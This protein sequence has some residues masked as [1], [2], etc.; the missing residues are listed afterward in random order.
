[1][2]ESPKLLAT[3]S[4]R[5]NCPDPYLAIQ[6][7]RDVYSFLVSE[8]KVTNYNLLQENFTANWLVHHALRNSTVL[9]YIAVLLAM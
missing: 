5:Y 9:F 6:Y 8:I 3:P 1:M 4:G 7:D 2:Y